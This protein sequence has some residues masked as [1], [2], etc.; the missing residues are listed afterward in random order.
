MEGREKKP[1]W[2]RNV[3]QQ[4]ISV[5]MYP[6]AKE[7]IREFARDSGSRSVSEFVVKAVYFDRLIAMFEREGGKATPKL[8]AMLVKPITQLA[9]IML[10]DPGKAERLI[11]RIERFVDRAHRQLGKPSFWDEL[12]YYAAIILGVPE[13][14]AR[15]IY[16]EKRRRGR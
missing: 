16:L 11:Q 4:L 6:Q 3:V 2:K 9:E 7:D 8:I 14:E 10:H 5:S 15:R 1:P 12:N 13:E